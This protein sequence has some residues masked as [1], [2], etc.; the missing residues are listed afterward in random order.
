MD[1]LELLK[2]TKLPFAELIG[3]RLTFAP[4]DRV[5]AD[6]VCETSCAPIRRCCTAVQ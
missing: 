3:L 4:P 2:Q 6:L 1:S 5:A